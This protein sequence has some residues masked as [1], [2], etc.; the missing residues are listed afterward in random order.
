M[1]K[2]ASKYDQS[3]AYA[4]L[5]ADQLDKQVELKNEISMLNE[6]TTILKDQIMALKSENEELKQKL[7]TVP[8]N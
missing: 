8:S 7:K 3:N 2:E 6:I 4:E 5:I 1:A